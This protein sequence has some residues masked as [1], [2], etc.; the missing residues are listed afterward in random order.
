[1]HHSTQITPVFFSYGPI[2]VL[3]PTKLF[4]LFVFRFL[5]VLSFKNKIIYFNKISFK[6]TTS[7]FNFCCFDMHE[8]NWMNI[9][10]TK[11]VYDRMLYIYIYKYMYI[12][13]Y[14]YI[15]IYIYFF[16][17]LCDPS[18]RCSAACMVFPQS[19]LF[20][21]KKVTVVTHFKSH[22]AS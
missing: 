5:A 3:E 10:K 20:C 2:P 9:M 14:V 22:Q 15:F 4:L 1:M 11:L 8:W 6:N 19:H 16:L 21:A 13:I 18:W 12:Y 7:V 17:L